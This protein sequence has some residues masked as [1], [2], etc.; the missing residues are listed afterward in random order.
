MGRSKMRLIFQLLAMLV[1]VPA[2]YYFI[3]WVPFSLIPFLEQRWVPGI[4]S[5][6]CAVAVGRYTWKMLSSTSEGLISSIL[7]GAMVLGAIGF[8]AGFFGPIF[9]TPGANQ[10]P[11]LGIFITGPL[12]F[13]L[14]GIG[15]FMYWFVKG[16]KVS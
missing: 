8:C 10:G 2:T 5:L 13:I 1:V 3:Y 16:R 9:F 12:G 6:L 15:G 7:F 11:L 4:V 14:G